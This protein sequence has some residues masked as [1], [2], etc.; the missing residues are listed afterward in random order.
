MRPLIGAG[1]PKE[2]AARGRALL[3]VVHSNDILAIVIVVNADADGA[4]GFGILIIAV[5]ANPS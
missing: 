5:A 3:L 2:A 4:P 1:T